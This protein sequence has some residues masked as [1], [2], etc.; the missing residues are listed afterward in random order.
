MA[1]ALLIYG[2][3]GYTAKLLALA[4]LER[5]VAPVLGGRSEG[6]PRVPPA[7]P[8][9]STEHR[10]CDLAGLPGFDDAEPRTD[11]G[12]IDVDEAP[13]RASEAAG[14]LRKATPTVH[15]VRI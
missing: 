14:T 11:G 1:D 2:A 5:G 4:V 6:K 13:R 9:A 12:A 3:T 10:G 15:G 7:T 8:N